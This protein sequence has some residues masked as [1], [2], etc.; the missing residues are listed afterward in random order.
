MFPPRPSVPDEQRGSGSYP[1]RF[2]DL[3][4]DR[5]LLLETVVASVG[6]ALWK[7][8]LSRHPAALA[9]NADGVRPI[10]T[11][12]IID[13]GAARFR[14]PAELTASGAYEL[15]SERAPDGTI[16]RL[17]LNMWTEIETMPDDRVPPPRLFAEH[18]LTRPFGPP[19]K[20]RVTQVPGID[21]PRTEYRQPPVHETLALPEGA[22]WL[23]PSLRADVRPNVFGLVHTDIN[24]HV[25]SLVYPRLFEEAALRRF[26]DLGRETK[27]LSRKLEI[28]FKKP[29]FAGQVARIAL[30]AFA[31]G[32]RLGAVGVF[33]EGNGG[34]DA[35]FEGVRANAYVRMWFEG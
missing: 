31:A 14:F 19:E 23:E 15:A 20:R 17:Y 28:T 5:R 8:V 32:E 3:S 1:I 10:F 29:F 7:S 34:A 18:V 6:P 13:G 27:V 21:P 35:T 22:A 30:R 16:A 9:M 2:E 33:V 4:Q 24:Q 25:N 26:A 12:M 11:R